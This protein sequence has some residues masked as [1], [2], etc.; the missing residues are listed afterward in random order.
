MK[1]ID[2]NSVIFENKEISRKECNIKELS[3]VKNPIA[4][5]GAGNQA[6]NIDN[7][8]K[9]N[10]IIV[11]C[12]IETSAFYTSGKLINE[13]PVYNFD[14]FISLPGKYEI[15]VGASGK[16]VCDFVRVLKKSG[17]AN[18]IYYMNDFIH[19]LFKMPIQFIKDNANTLNELYDL[20]E[21]ELSKNILL[22]YLKINCPSIS[23]YSD[24]YESYFMSTVFP[25]DI[26]KQRIPSSIVD[27]G[28]WQGDTIEDYLEYSS[29]NT[30]NKI[31]VYAF[32]A[33]SDNYRRLKV[34]SEKL[35]KIYDASIECFPCAVDN[36][37]HYIQF[38]AEGTLCSS[39]RAEVIQKNNTTMVKAVTLDSTI[40]NKKIELIKMDIEGGELPALQGAKEIIQ[41][42][43]PYLAICV[44]H[45]LEDLITIPQ[46]IKSITE[47][48]GKKYKYYLRVHEKDME[49][50]LYT[51][52]AG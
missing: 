49:L 2:F 40:G 45:R 15:V 47:D 18:K 22:S 6:F 35:N 24:D 5:F 30:Q 26:F 39:N 28:A 44:Y 42:Q 32:E 38:F 36:E 52:P 29:N 10:N 12:F 50:D 34:T 17:I 9:S 27:C 46:Y 11:D 23:F 13:K 25:D 21:D 3:L 1:K 43:M 41:K 8:L 19:P 7:I 14:K 37:N 16:G 20:L 31:S 48:V 51:V 33:D 4:I